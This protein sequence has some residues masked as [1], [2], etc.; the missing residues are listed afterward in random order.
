[1]TQQAVANTVEYNKIHSLARAR[2]VVVN[3]FGPN[4]MNFWPMADDTNFIRDL[5]RQHPLAVKGSPSLKQAGMID[6][7]IQ[8]PSGSYISDMTPDKEFS[9][10]TTG[11]YTDYS[12]KP[13]SGEN[14]PI[15]LYSGLHVHNF[16]AS[17]TGTVTVKV[18]LAPANLNPNQLD[19][20]A[21]AYATYSQSV[22]SGEWY[23]FDVNFAVPALVTATGYWFYV[24]WTG[25]TGNLRWMNSNSP[26][27]NRYWSGSAW[28]SISGMRIIWLTALGLSDA[29]T[30][31]LLDQFCVGAWVNV[32]DKD[33]VSG[34]VFTL[35]S[36]EKKAQLF[37]TSDKKAQGYIKTASGT[38]STLTASTR[39]HPGYNLVTLSYERNVASTGIKLGVNGKVV[40]Q[41]TSPDE[42]LFNT[43]LALCIGGQQLTTKAFSSGLSDAVVDDVF[44]A[45]DVPT[46]DE[47]W[48][49]YLSYITAAPLMTVES[50]QLVP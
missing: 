3:K 30:Y 21:I 26:Y 16:Y 5:L 1:M 39:L 43:T 8:L 41:T 37:V 6:Y 33:A 38:T 29:L 50:V 13:V 15:G 34:A 7:A 10:S 28:S 27:E 18:W 35:A 23:A 22:T 32:D 9:G 17:Q 45:K 47:L 31:G 48:D 11:G 49:I 4:L 42:A 36:T 24:D 12:L 25:V 19:A 46:D 44:V 20:Q 40:A 14:V 2:K